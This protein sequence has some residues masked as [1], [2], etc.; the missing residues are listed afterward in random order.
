MVKMPNA[1]RRFRRM[2]K[3]RVS[4]PVKR[5]VRNALNRDKET[6]QA[7]LGA[8]TMSPS[9]YSAGSLLTY[10]LTQI[11]QGDGA[12]DRDGNLIKVTGFYARFVCTYSDTTNI[13]RFR[14]WMPKSNNTISATSVDYSDPVDQD[15]TRDFIDKIVTVGSGGPTQRTVI[16]KKKF[17][18]PLYFRYYGSA[19]TNI[20]TP[21]LMLSIGSDSGAVSHPTVSGHYR[22]Y[23]KDV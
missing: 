12:S 6:K 3:P 9:T 17:K 8:M 22:V 14:L 21:Y 20:V 5:Y 2:R 11:A 1:R 10:V 4:V 13:I 23:W 19:G 15:T 7:T 18:K 16:L